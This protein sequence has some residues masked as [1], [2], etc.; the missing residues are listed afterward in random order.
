[1]LIA[2]VPKTNKLAR[3]LFKYFYRINRTNIIV[4]DLGPPKEW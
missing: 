3:K 1:L 2:S 4:D